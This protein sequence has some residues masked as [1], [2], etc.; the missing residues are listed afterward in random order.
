MRIKK[1]HLIWSALAAVLALAVQP[2]PSEACQQVVHNDRGECRC[3]EMGDEGFGACMQLSDGACWV[4]GV[5]SG[6]P[7]R[8]F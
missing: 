6:G 4:T 5:C 8:P 7:R 3:K 2:A 1:A